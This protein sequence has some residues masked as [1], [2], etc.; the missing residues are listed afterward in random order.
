MRCAQAPL[1]AVI[2]GVCPPGTQL[3]DVKVSFG[4]KTL[5]ATIGKDLGK[6]TWMVKLPPT[7][8][9]FT[10]VNITASSGGVDLTLANVL[11]GD[12]WVCS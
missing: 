5:P 7:P 6:T 11:F 2:W 8:A 4:G 12:V 3:G 9:S 10:P 1:Q